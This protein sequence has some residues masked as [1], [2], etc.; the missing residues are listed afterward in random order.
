LKKQFSIVMSSYS[1]ETGIFFNMETTMRNIAGLEIK[2]KKLRQTIFKVFYHAGGGHLP[3]ALSIAEIITSLY[4]N[5]LQIDPLIPNDP[6]RDRFI[7]SKGHACMALYSILAEKGF[8]PREHLFKMC[9]KDSILGGHPDMLKTPGVEASTGSLGQGLPYAVGV[10]LSAK[11]QKQNFNVYCVVGDGECQEGSIW[12]SLLYA[13]QQKLD[14]LIVIVDYNKLQAID[15]INKTNDISPLV[16]KF[17]SFGLSV[18]EIDGHDLAS[19]G[20]TFDQI[21]FK[22]EYPSL[23]VS[24]TTKGKG[25][26]FMENVPIWHY[27]M[28]ND[29]ELFVVLEELGL[30]QQEL[31][32]L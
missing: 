14:N 18:K 5:Y 7:L 29:E 15:F 1:I 19:I 25:V 16:S 27:R 12:E 26:S 21:P 32:E 8:F 17:E 3:S 4:E 11:L 30:T 22:K 13:S 6:N 31:N 2:T 9:R 20:N 24:N 28:T 10:A 23:I